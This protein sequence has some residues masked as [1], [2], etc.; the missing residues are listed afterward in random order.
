MSS[1][2]SNKCSRC[3]LIQSSNNTNCNR[4]ATPLSTNQSSVS[5]PIR[6]N[7]LFSGFN[8]NNTSNAHTKYYIAGTV[9]LVIV[10]VLLV[11]FPKV[12]VGLIVGL[13]VL[14]FG[15]A[16]F[17]GLFWLLFKVRKNEEK[18]KQDKVNAANAYQQALLE[19]RNNPSNPMLKQ[20]ALDAGRYS[21]GLNRGGHVAI[22][23]ELAI[24]N[25]IDAC[26]GQMPMP[27]LPAYQQPPAVLPQQLQRNQMSIDQRLGQLEDLKSRGLINQDEYSDRRKAI[28]NNL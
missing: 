23:D 10:L 2:S 11:V 24:K 26:A 4:C 1:N 15:V 3:G 16:M 14:A 19:L 27:P 12:I 6:D 25:E 17:G 18:K 7:Q 28:L 9:A 13:F 21:A 8:E 5:S 20:K 22:F